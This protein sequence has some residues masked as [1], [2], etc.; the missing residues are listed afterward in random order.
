M[1][2]IEISKL[3]SKE[4]IDGFKAKLIN[5]ENIT[6]SYVSIKA[7]AILPE[8]S[9]FHEQ[10]TQVTEGKPEMTIDGTTKILIPGMVAIIPSNIKHS[11][12]ALTDCKVTDIFYPVREDYK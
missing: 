7:N 10:I 9:H 8:H 1:N 6:L 5:T 4:I 12:R 3:P 11:G 2:E